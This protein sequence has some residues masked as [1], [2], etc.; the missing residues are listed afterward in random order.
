M[1]GQMSAHSAF[2]ATGRFFKRR[3]IVT[4]KSYRVLFLGPRKINQQAGLFC[5][6][7][8]TKTPV[9]TF[10]LAGIFVELLAGFEP[11]TC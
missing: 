8:Q 9:S 11:A 3:P 7:N 4:T 1:D 6:A 10:V 2:G 5:P